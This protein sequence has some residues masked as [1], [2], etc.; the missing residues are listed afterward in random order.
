MRMKIEE[1]TI[2][3][4]EY[5]EKLRNIYDSPQKIYVLGNKKLLEQQAIA[6]VGARKSTIYG[7]KVAY[8][9]SKEL[10]ENGINI[11]SGLAIGID[12]CA[13]LG[14]VQ[15]YNN[16]NMN[17]KEVSNIGKTIAVLGSGIDNIYPKENTELARKIIKTGGCIISEYPLG[18]KP[19]RLHF[20]QRNRIMSALS[21]GIL[22]VEASK[23]SGSLITA[24][25]ALE[26]GKE[27]FSIP[28]DITREQSQGCN[29][30]IKDGATII[31]STQ[32]ILDIIKY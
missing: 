4:K 16:K 8:K 24:E 7:R 18:S 23:A 26:Q 31:T 13:H 15:A 21:D 12:T 20:P 3:S 29:E 22:V 11:I 14:A 5:P 17:I 32:E 2:K 28:G 6:V 27:V 25:F 30:L 1:I 19:E 10:A 9:I